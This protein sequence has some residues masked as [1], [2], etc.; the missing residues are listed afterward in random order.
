MSSGGFD[1]WEWGAWGI[2]IVVTTL[3]GIVATF[4]K[5]IE[6]R[7]AKDIAALTLINERLE[8]E[9]A[10]MRRTQLTMT[11][12][13]ATLKAENATLKEMIHNLEQRLQRYEQGHGA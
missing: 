11:A 13:N 10:E 8:K 2:G 3:A 9:M 5:I 7:N 4:W 1:P 12:E 6:N